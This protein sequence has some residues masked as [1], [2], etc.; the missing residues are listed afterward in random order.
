MKRPNRQLDDVRAGLGLKVALSV[1]VVANDSG[2]AVGVEDAAVVSAQGNLQD[3]L[4][5]HAVQ[6]ALVGCIRAEESHR[7]VVLED[8]SV[9]I[10]QIKLLD[11]RFSTRNYD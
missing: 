7:P 3:V 10:S 8:S 1:A 11:V 4:I 5:G 6:I 9:S 2:R